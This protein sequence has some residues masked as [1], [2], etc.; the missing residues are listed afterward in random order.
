[1]LGYSAYISHQWKEAVENYR[2]A[3]EYDP[4]SLFLRTEIG[5]ILSRT[6]DLSGALDT[7]REVLKENPDYVP[8]LMIMADISLGQK[9][10]IRLK[11]F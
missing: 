3:L 10:T 8:A 6:G 11:G 7:I 1:M 4:K 2:K 5:F 9:K